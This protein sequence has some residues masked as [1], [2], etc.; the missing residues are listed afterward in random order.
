MHDKELDDLMKDVAELAHD[1]EWADSSDISIEKYY[2]T[3]KQ[4]KQ[5]WFKADRETRLKGFIDDA[6][7]ELR[8]ELYLLIGEDDEK[9]T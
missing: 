6:I 2:D 3:I 5:K 7:K 9:T 8:K 1:L 4:F